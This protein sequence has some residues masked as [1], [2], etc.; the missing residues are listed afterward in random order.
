MCV[1]FC[2]VSAEIQCPSFDKLP[3]IYLSSASLI[4]L[5]AGDASW[6]ILNFSE[7]AKSTILS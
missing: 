6:G 5:S 7:P 4:Y 2:T 3:F 1:L